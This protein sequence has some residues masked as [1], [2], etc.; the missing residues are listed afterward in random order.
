MLHV[1]NMNFGTTQKQ[2]SEDCTF[3][4]E[5]SNVDMCCFIHLNWIGLSGSISKIYRNFSGMEKTILHD[6][7]LDVFFNIRAKSYR[8]SWFAGRL[9]AKNFYVKQCIPKQNI[10]WKNIRIASRNSFGKSVS[11][12]LLVND[13]DTGF[14]FSISHVAD[15]AIVVVPTCFTEGI[16]CDLVYRE[17]STPGIAKIFFHDTEIDVSQNQISFDS[18]WAIKEAAYKSCKCK[19]AFQPRQWLTQKIKENHYLCRHLDLNQQLFADVE[20]LTI[21]EYILA[22]ARRIR[23]GPLCNNLNKNIISL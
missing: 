16:G 11:P 17:T 12:Q 19:E 6:K 22:V 13:V 3:R 5:T 8:E 2:V 10:A 4:H 1:K 21:G 23:C 7:E 14:T 18:V 20:T 9:L 15:K